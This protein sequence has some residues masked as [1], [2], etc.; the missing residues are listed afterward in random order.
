MKKLPIAVLSIISAAV[1]GSVTVSAEEAV[2]T[3]PKT[4]YCYEY[5][6]GGLFR[7][8]A[9]C[10]TALIYTVDDPSLL[11]IDSTGLVTVH[12]VGETTVTISTYGD[13]NFTP[14]SK[15]I[16]VKIV[17]GTPTPKIETT[18]IYYG[19]SFSEVEVDCSTGV[20][21]W[22]NLPSEI[23]VP[24]VYTYQAIYT[25]NDTERWNSCSIPID[26]TVFPAPAEPVYPGGK[27]YFSTEIPYGGA[28]SL[29]EDERVFVSTITG[30][31]VEGSHVYED[32]TCTWIGETA[33]PIEAQFVPTVNSLY[34][35]CEYNLMVSGYKSDISVTVGDA[36]CA[37]FDPV[38]KCIPN[39]IVTNASGAPIDYVIDWENPNEVL[40]NYSVGTVDF[41]IIPKDTIHYNV[42]HG[43]MNVHME[44]ALIPC[45]L[46]SVSSLEYGQKLSDIVLD[47]KPLIDA[48]VSLT[49]LDADIVPEV[50]EAYEVVALLQTDADG[51]VDT[52]F[53]FEVQVFRS[54]PKLTNV[55]S[56]SQEY[57]GNHLGSWIVGGF[58]TNKYTGIPVGGTFSWK[59]P[60]AIPEVDG[61]YYDVVFT[62]YDNKNY[63]EVSI[64]VTPLV[65]PIDPVLNVR[66]T[67]IFLGQ[68]LASSELIH[69]HDGVIQWVV[70]ETVPTLADSGLTEYPIQFTS[71]TPNYNNI[72]GTCRVNVSKPT[73]NGEGITVTPIH[74][75]QSLREATLSWDKDSIAGYYEW[76]YPDTVPEVKDSNVTMYPI[77]FVSTDPEYGSNSEIYMTVTVYTKQYDPSDFGDMNASVI[78]FGDNLGQS[79]VEGS[80]PV[81]GKFQWQEPN[82]HPAVTDNNGATY[83][84]T[85][86][87]NDSNNYAPVVGIPCNIVVKRANISFTDEE[88]YSIEATRLETGSLLKES[89]ITAG[90]F[91]EGAFEW[92]YPDTR[93][94][95]ENGQFQ[96]FRARFVPA[97]NSYNPVENLIVTVRVLDSV[98]NITEVKIN[99][100]TSLIYGQSLSDSQI[101]GSAPVPGE[102]RWAYPTIKPHVADSMETPYTII[103]VPE[104][105]DIATVRGL[106]STV[107]VTPATID[108]GIDDVIAT[109]MP[110][111]AGT[112]LGDVT[113]INILDIPGKIVP[114]NPKQTPTVKDTT[115]LVNFIPEGGDYYP[116]ENAKASIEVTPATFKAEQFSNLKVTPVTYGEELS[117]S[118][119]SCHGPVSGTYAWASPTITPTYSDSL[120]TQYEIIFTPVDK[121]NYAPFTL[122]STVEVIKPMAP[123]TE[124]ILK[125]LTVKPLT[126][127]MNLGYAT[128]SGKKP[129]AGDWVWVAPKTLPTVADSN[130]TEYE[131][132]FVPKDSNY[133]VWTGGTLKVTVE[134]LALNASSFSTI[135]CSA[136][137][138]GEPLSKSVISGKCVVPGTF[139]WDTPDAIPSNN[140]YTEY[141][142]IFTPTDTANIS[143]YLFTAHPRVNKAPL[144]LIKNDIEGSDIDYGKPI[145]ESKI[146]GSSPVSSIDGK[147]VSGT[148]YW[149]D[150][151]HTPSV[152]EASKTS[153]GVVYIPDDIENYKY[154]VTSCDLTV[155]KIKPIF[156]TKDITLTYSDE[157]VNLNVY[158]N[159]P[160]KISAR[161]NEE[162]IVYLENNRFK[163]MDAGE[164]TV[165]LKIAESSNYLSAETDFKIT[166]E[167]KTTKI[168]GTS[169]YNVKE[170]EVK[171]FKLDAKNVEK[172]PML[173]T[174]SGSSVSVDENGVVKV[175]QSGTSTI[176]VTFKDK[177]W[178]AEKLSIA[179]SVEKANTSTSSGSTGS[180]PNDTKPVI[181]VTS[182]SLT[183]KYGDA[184]FK[185]VVNN[186][187]GGT[188]TYKSQ[189]TEVLTINNDTAH[190][191]GIGSA[192]VVAYV[193]NTPATSFTVTVEKGTPT[194]GDAPTY[195][196][197]LD[198]SRFAAKDT[199][200]SSGTRT[201]VS[202]NES[203]ATVTKEGIV[204]LHGVGTAIITVTAKETSTLSE[205]KQTLTIYVSEPSKED[206]TTKVPAD[207]TTLPGIESLFGGGNNASTG[208]G[209][210]PSNGL[211]SSGDIALDDVIVLPESIVTTT[212]VVTTTAP[213]EAED[214]STTTTTDVVEDSV[215]TVPPVTDEEFTEEIVD[216]LNG[217]F[218]DNIIATVMQNLLIVCIVGGV[219]VVGII[220]LIVVLINKGK[221]RKASNQ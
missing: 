215:T 194:V 56:H 99:S 160:G 159:S 130:K 5:A 182:S 9:Q 52:F 72:R 132:K 29:T 22:V 108:I 152:P 143:S 217:S 208:D 17:K 88:L 113:F 148:W 11:S 126:Y 119:I 163:C 21:S 82:I 32:A 173:Y 65:I 124:D 219:L 196:K 105:E 31:R 76:V 39:L 53:T 18:P 95:I 64:P 116:L 4:E 218:F 165:T 187:N 213:E 25:P 117:T 172:A 216:E 51:Y 175:L 202:S 35:G 188:V 12:D 13:T 71:N 87:P 96:E 186:P 204:N 195:N 59:F 170:G 201:Y 147:A 34:S 58:A 211:P 151:T 55:Q 169:V 198:D 131:I 111:E 8:G 104:D 136:I 74:Y 46:L 137:T 70:P 103:F 10:E 150:E 43:S 176:T 144:K 145:G 67:D 153:Y 157:P 20:I 91:I 207:V 125:S 84:C 63:T 6:P 220:V 94:Y 69:A 189:N 16:T 110:F 28:L 97:S 114:V 200:N 140:D 62:P 180:T 47:Y 167:P 146:K 49:I 171:S 135:T 203:V 210:K 162:G 41:T 1:I 107:R 129:C 33:L 191:T 42:W 127:G 139:M 2:I 106:Y 40:P 98:P 24:G 101:I 115:A 142:I 54:E 102:F 174:V 120:K 133:R 205:A 61:T 212:T 45:N 122:K 38:S 78:Y 68:S 66:A 60:E 158:T 193:N 206:T 27:D 73:E 181:D 81:P 7:I 128:I 50:T 221:K 179:V 199:I 155:N 19:E 164:T 89:F 90:T 178:G 30:E 154:Y 83:Y 85:F 112:E 209:K 156:Q 190:I 48:D 161:I 121:D 77:K 79:L 100:T 184:D 37:N 36:V 92:V 93:V 183:K 109:S 134:K 177:K 75:G 141:Q 138:Y 168:T 14:S 23:Q 86:I 3:V 149:I 80:S 118:T 123:V 57:Y 185:L 26:L 15:T 166:V 44:G 214:T 192:V 197:T